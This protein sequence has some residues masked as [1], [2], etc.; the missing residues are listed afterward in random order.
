MSNASSIYQHDVGG[1]RQGGKLSNFR[2]YNIFKKMKDPQSRGRLRVRDL[3]ADRPGMDEEKN[4]HEHKE[5]A[6]LGG[7]SDWKV[8]DRAPHDCLY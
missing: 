8:A 7:E 6:R 4:H 3:H 2:H 1:K 5:P